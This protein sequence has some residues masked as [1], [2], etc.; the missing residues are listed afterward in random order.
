[1]IDGGARSVA[2]DQI[3]QAVADALDGGDGEFHR[4]D[5]GFDA[6]GAE[7][8][9]ALVGLGGIPDAEGHGTD[10]RTMD[11]GEALGKAFRLGIEDE[12]DVALA[13]KR[14][15]LRPVLRHGG[16]AHALEQGCQL[17]GFGCGIFDELE[18]VGAHGVVEQVGHAVLPELDLRV[19]SIWRTIA[20]ESRR[21]C[22]RRE[23]GGFMSSGPLSLERF[24]PYRLSIVT[25]RISGALS[26]HYATR[27]G[28]G[29]PEWRV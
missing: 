2:V 9:G 25:N 29:I 22:A 18:T 14:D 19:A 21:E 10:R 20:T 12:V 23:K 7:L 24:L 26:R 13:I 1:I 8:A 28:I 6:P 27:F 3:D 17:G 5:M 4:P 11:A 16:K 15:V